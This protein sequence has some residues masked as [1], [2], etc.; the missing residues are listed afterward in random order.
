MAEKNGPSVTTSHED[1]VRRHMDGLSLAK[2]D[3]TAF[4]RQPQRSVSYTAEKI[5]GQG[6]FGVV[7][8]ARVVETS[9]LV[10]IKKVLQDRRFKNREL[11]IMRMIVHPNVISMKH[12]FFSTGEQKGEVYLNLVLEYVP[13][14]L[15]QFL[16]SHVRR[17]ERM[18]EVYVQLFT[19]QLLRALNYLHLRG[20]CH[21]DVKPQNLLID[22][23][24]GIL[25]ICDFGSAKL[26][27]T[28]EPNVSYICSRYYRAP[29]LIFGATDYSASID[30]WSAGC[31]MSELL[32]GKPLFCGETS[33]DQLVEIIKVL[34]TPAS[35]EIMSMNPSYTEFR[36][37]DVK[38]QTWNEIF[39]HVS[40]SAIDLITSLLCYSPEKRAT[41]A[42]AMQ[43]PYFLP[44]KDPATRLPDGQPLPPGL[45]DF[46]EEEL[47]S[48]SEEARIYF[49]SP[50]D[51]L[52]G[53]PME[54]DP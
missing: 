16:R 52:A 6:S 42:E 19:Y 1:T 22:P 21:R 25:K 35:E 44:L 13:S 31:V 37:P 2:P 43:H 11:Q 14:T 4:S 18:P 34:G 7:F 17:H 5:I 47:E 51:S 20:V 8:L 24:L 49:L 48:F 32:L 29:E 12:C 41:A 38:G 54:E 39:D 27:V 36:F 26:L 9:E 53:T 28:G 33:V 15:Y 45:F 40:S 23:A 30:V 50:F 10:A 3:E 46:C